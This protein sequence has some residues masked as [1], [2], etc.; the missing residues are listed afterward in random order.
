[1]SIVGRENSEKITDNSEKRTVDYQSVG[2][3]GGGG[4]GGAGGIM[5]ISNSFTTTSSSH[6]M[7]T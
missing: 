1:M 3:G 2:G 4:G 5:I 6:L 7:P